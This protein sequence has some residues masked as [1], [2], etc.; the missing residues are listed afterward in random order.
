MVE[1]V[2]IQVCILVDVDWYLVMLVACTASGSWCLSIWF[3]SGGQCVV[4]VWPTISKAS[5]EVL[6]LPH[7]AHIPC[8]FNQALRCSSDR[9]RSSKLI[10]LVLLFTLWR[11]FNSRLGSFP[12]VSCTGS[13]R[14]CRWFPVLRRRLFEFLSFLSTKFD[15]VN[16]LALS[17]S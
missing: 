7:P 10:L 3:F 5:R 14:Y 12:E 13:F 11:N 17:L 6:S 2:T 15:E 4:A 1:Y 8:R 16:M 9:L